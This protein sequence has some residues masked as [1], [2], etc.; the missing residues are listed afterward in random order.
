[1]AEPRVDPRHQATA[2]I[3]QQMRLELQA[4]SLMIKS[5]QEK[6]IA[7]QAML[8][9]HDAVLYQGKDAM[10]TQIAIFARS[11]DDLD[12]WRRAV[13]IYR[14]N[15]R[16]LHAQMHQESDGKVLEQIK[17]Q[18]QLANTMLSTHGQFRVALI[19]GLVSI[20]TVVLTA[21]LVHLKWLPWLGK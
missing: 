5:I 6:L 19:T 7:M 8:D 17:G 16:V 12:S 10:Q 14:E 4:D 20:G 3:L 21:F 1:M 9:A 2:D 15:I 11:L 13:D 18:N